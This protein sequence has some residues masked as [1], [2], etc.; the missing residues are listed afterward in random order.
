MRSRRSS[1]YFINRRNFL[2]ADMTV[3]YN[4]TLSTPFSGSAARWQR[5][6]TKRLGPT[7]SPEEYL[8]NIGAFPPYSC[9]GAF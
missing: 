2:D 7:E 9:G 1:V 6:E 5:R 3:G 4:R 8:R